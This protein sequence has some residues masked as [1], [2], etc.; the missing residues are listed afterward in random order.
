MDVVF[1]TAYSN[2]VTIYILDDTADEREDLG[3][4]VLPYA[5]TCAFHVEN[6]VYV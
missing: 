2:R 3:K 1:D 6:D 5:D 4:V